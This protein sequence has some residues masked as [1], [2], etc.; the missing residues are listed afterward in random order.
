MVLFFLNTPRGKQ[1]SGELEFGQ[2][3]LDGFIGS[4]LGWLSRLGDSQNNLNS[5]NRT[6]PT[7][8]RRLLALSSFKLC[9][10]SPQYLLVSTIRFAQVY[11]H[12]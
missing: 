5:R 11:V 8:L 1:S 6:D 10:D 4:L 3:P 9:H 2:Q 12:L 7:L